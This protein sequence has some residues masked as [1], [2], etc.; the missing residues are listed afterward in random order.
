M[1]I[2][3]AVFATKRRIFVQAFR[4]CLVF[5]IS[6]PLNE[7]AG[8]LGVNEE[9]DSLL[10]NFARLKS[11]HDFYSLWIKNPFK[12]DESTSELLDGLLIL[13]NEGRR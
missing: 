6:A 13:E 10:L 4:V 5:L 2:I 7:D 9:S 8:E 11:V 1:W 12:G 3:Q